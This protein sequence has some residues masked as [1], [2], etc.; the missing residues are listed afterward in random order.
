MKLTIGQ[1]CSVFFVALVVIYFFYCLHVRNNIEYAIEKEIEELEKDWKLKEVE[2]KR[3]KEELLDV[4]DVLQPLSEDPY[5]GKTIIDNRIVFQDYT[6]SDRHAIVTMIG[7]SSYVH[8]YWMGAVAM[9]QSLREV[10]T[11]VPHIIVLVKEKDQ[12]PL[13]AEEALLRLGAELMPIENTMFKLESM[14]I[15]GTWAGAFEK[16]QVWGLIQFDKVLFLDADT[17]IVQNVDH[18][19]NHPE[20][21][22]PYTPTNCQCNAEYHKDPVYFTISSGFFV[23]EPSMERMNQIITLANNPSPDPADQEQFGGTWHWGDQEMLRVVFKQLADVTG[24][25]WNALDWEYDLPVGMCSCP[26]RRTRPIYSYHFVCTFPVSKPW[27]EP[28]PSLFSPINP[29][30]DCVVE[31]YRTW[32][33]LF[34]KGMNGWTMEDMNRAL[35]EDKLGDKANT[36][37]QQRQPPNSPA[38]NRVV[39]A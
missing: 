35:E 22:A 3:S 30:P 27:G 32:F 13:I 28:F 37:L 8:A 11:R 1:A 20:L 23:C 14:Q 39:W 19:L 16:L 26:Q 25:K 24:R 33:R 34:L 5:K 7:S 21:T 31:I 12:L 15:P 2:Y 38:K 18:L 17:L 36:I 29:R 10:Q 9:I 4:I 6:P